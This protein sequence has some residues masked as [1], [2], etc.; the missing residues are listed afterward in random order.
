MVVLTVGFRGPR[1]VGIPE[2]QPG[3]VV[4]FGPGGAPVALNLPD[5][6]VPPGQEGQVVG[7]G[8]GGAP[9]AVDAL[10]ASAD[11]ENQIEQRPD[12]LFVGPPQ[13]SSNQW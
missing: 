3:Q 10:G 11:P 4:G 13:L 1:G 8:P 2:G 9:R 5:G 12:G 7:Y 6:T